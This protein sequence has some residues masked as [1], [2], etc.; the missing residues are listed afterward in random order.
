MLTV[1]MMTP[2]KIPMPGLVGISYNSAEML[3]RNTKLILADTIHKADINSGGVLEQLYDGHP[4]PPGDMIAQGSKISLVIGDG[5]GNT[6]HEVPDVTTLSVDAA[7]TILDQYHLL[8]EITV[9]DPTQ[10]I[11]DTAN[12]T[13]M[14]QI[15]KDKNEAGTPNHIKDGDKIILIVN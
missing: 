2:P 3:L 1:N 5:A 7:R 11:A 10:K 14:E 6:E 4:I 13:V 9:K 12:A 15:P 8:V